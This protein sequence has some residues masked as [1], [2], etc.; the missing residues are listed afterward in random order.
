VRGV[1]HN[2]AFLRDL[3]DHPRFVEGRLT[4]G[5]IREVRS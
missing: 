1:G 2:I 3:A 5:F 4:T